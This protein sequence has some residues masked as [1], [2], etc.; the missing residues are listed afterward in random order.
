MSQRGDRD[1]SSSS[2]PVH[3]RTDGVRRDAFFCRF[4]SHLLLYR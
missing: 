2:P 3:E 1:T 4:E